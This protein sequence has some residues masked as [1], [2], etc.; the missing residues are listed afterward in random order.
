MKEAMKITE[1]TEHLK[2]EWKATVTFFL[3]FVTVLVTILPNIIFMMI[4][5][6]MSLIS[7]QPPV[8]HIA[9]IITTSLIRIHLITDPIVIMRD[10]DIKKI[11]SEIKVKMVR[12]FKCN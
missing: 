7:S 8:L 4:I 2:M 5:D 9:S 10:Q 12:A 6:R 3:L 1:K 11:L